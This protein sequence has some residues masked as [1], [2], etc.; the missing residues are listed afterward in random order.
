MK[1]NPDTG[2]GERLEL[3]R[4]TV[5]DAAAY[6]E[7]INRQDDQSVFQRF[8]SI[9]RP[10]ASR[11]ARLLERAGAR[12]EYIG[13]FCDGKLIAIGELAGGQLDRAE[14][15]LL[16]DEA[17][18]RHGIGTELFRRLAAE[19][20]ALGYRYLEGDSLADNHEVTSVLA[21]MPVKV[22]RRLHDGLWSY[23]V[24]VDRVLG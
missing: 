8:F 18:Q 19:A 4:L 17:W 20:K 5:D 21:D 13:A 14:V 12:H 23:V 2:L 22:M 1:A 10:S 15:A 3:R 24:D 16:V 7:L 6:A 11:A 9:D